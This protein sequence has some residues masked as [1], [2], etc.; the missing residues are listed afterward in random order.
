MN[1]MRGGQLDKCCMTEHAF[2]RIVWD[3]LRC[4]NIGQDSFENSC[5]T[6]EQVCDLVAH[7]NEYCGG[8]NT[9]TPQNLLN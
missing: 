7:L 6:K 1:K 8:C 3:V 2:S 4:A 9:Y 5:L